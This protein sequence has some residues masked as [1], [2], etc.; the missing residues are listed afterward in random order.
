MTTTEADILN[1]LVD[2]SNPTWT[3]EAAQAVLQLG[4]CEGD[5]QRMEELAQKSNRG[6]LTVDE[7]RELEGYVFVG[8]VLA[9]LKSKARASLRAHSSA[10]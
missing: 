8:D 3:P 1:R 7:H 9:L 10:A 5:H 6:E 4:Y 2:P